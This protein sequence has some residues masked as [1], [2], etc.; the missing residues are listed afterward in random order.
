MLLLSLSFSALGK[1]STAIFAGGCFWCMESAF[2]KLP[3]V[4]D[5]QSGYTGGTT[6]NPTYEQ[7]TGGFTG[8]YEAVKVTFDSDKISYEKLLAV[9]WRNI[10]PLDDKGQ[11]CDRGSSYR[12]AI[13]YQDENQRELAQ[14]S[15]LALIETKQVYKVVTPIIK[16]TEFYP[17]EAYHQNYYQKNPVRYRTYRYLCGR[18]QR[19]NEIWSQ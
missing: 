5:T 15:K 12:S 3:G 14:K 9:F 7:V 6:K 2:D 19:L 16:A 11:F 10:D 8:H 1:T 13:F 17:A 4:V 18:D